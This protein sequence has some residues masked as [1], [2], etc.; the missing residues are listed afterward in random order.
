MPSRSGILV[1]LL[2]LFI[3][4]TAA[5]C[6]PWRQNISNF[7]LVYIKI[8]IT[9]LFVWHLLALIYINFIF[10][11]NYLLFL[12]LHILLITRYIFSH[13]LTLELITSSNIYFQLVFN[14]ILIFQLF[15]FISSIH[16][17]W[18]CNAQIV[19][20]LTPKQSVHD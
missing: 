7:R 5:K 15:N 1:D 12:C 9:V 20:V 13:V 6:C 19:D 10:F 3:F 2:D 18:F 17:S 8:R 4:L 14:L 11:I 16:C